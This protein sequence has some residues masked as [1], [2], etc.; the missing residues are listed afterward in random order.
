MGALLDEPKL[1]VDALTDTDRLVFG[2]ERA[3]VVL[4]DAGGVVVELVLA[5]WEPAARAGFPHERVRLLAT[6]RSD[7]WVIPQDADDRRWK[8]RMPDDV[9]SGHFRELCLWRPG[10]DPAL[11]WQWVD[12]LVDLL[13]IV[14]RHL[15]YEEY[16]RR[17][18]EWP[19]EDA[20]HGLGTPKIGT[21]RM[22]EAAEEWSRS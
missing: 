8:H 1:V 5:P 22:Q 21:A 17:T 2:V 13:S 11:V 19:V 18:G 16:W 3:D 20:P 12:G 9:A 15:H 14:H 6:T 10:D 7:V 4:H